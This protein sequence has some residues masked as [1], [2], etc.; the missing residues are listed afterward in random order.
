M[1]IFIYLPAMEFNRKH[2]LVILFSLKPPH[3][4]IMAGLK[5]F[6][7]NKYMDI[8]FAKCVPLWQQFFSWL[9][10]IKVYKI[11]H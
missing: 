11:N 4:Y 7:T 1:F 5:G 6:D 8:Y 10:K 3:G 2:I 9:L